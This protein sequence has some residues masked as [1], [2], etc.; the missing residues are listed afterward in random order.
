VL[1]WLAC[2]AG[3]EIDASST[4]GIDEAIALLLLR[5]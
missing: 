4:I 1:N 3:M 5:P 2:E